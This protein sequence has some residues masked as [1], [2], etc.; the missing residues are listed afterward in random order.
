MS[1]DWILSYYEI[2]EYDILIVQDNK[3]KLITIKID[4]YEREPRNPEYYKNDSILH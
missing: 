2:E 3:G 1:E 4:E